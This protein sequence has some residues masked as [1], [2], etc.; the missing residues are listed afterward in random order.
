[1]DAGVSVLEWLFQQTGPVVAA[2]MALWFMQQNHKAYMERERV[3]A[4]IHRSDKDR[5]LTVFEKNTEANTRLIDAVTHL[6]SALL[7][8]EQRL[9]REAGKG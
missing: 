7:E 4:D 2:V 6:E 5:M 3:N 8:R 1:M 9:A